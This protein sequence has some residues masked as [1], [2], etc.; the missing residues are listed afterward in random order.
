[1][2]RSTLTYAHWLPC[3]RFL[4]RYGVLDALLSPSSCQPHYLSWWELA[5][6]SRGVQRRAVLT[7]GR[8]PAGLFKKR[9]N[10]P[11]LTSP[12]LPIPAIQLPSSKRLCRV[13][14]ALFFFFSFLHTLFLFPFHL[15]FVLLHC[16]LFAPFEYCRSLSLAVLTSRCC[17]AEG[18]VDLQALSYINFHCYMTA[19]M[20]LWVMIFTQRGSR[21]PWDIALL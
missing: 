10:T 7:L 13:Y 4:D 14:R 18:H 12:L 3:G 21:L 2:C 1:M 20:H 16:L 19:E 6:L 11:S 17:A 15:V 8:V 9:D 5:Q